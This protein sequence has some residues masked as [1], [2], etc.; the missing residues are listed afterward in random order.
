[1]AAF[2]RDGISFDPPDGWREMSITSL[3]KAPSPG[4]PEACTFIVS[5]EPLGPNESLRAHVQKKLL[6]VSKALPK[7]EYGDTLD[8]E[9]GG[10]PSIV[11]RYAWENEAT[12]VLQTLIAVELVTRSGRAALVISTTSSEADDVAHRQAFD[13]MNASFRFPSEADGSRP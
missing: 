5:N 9:L 4:T 2:E 8:G 3:T 13:E 12:R 6:T 1:M 10:R 11:M 7:F